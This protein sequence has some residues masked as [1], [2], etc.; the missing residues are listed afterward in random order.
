MKLNP[1]DLEKI[2]DLTLKH[3]NQS[4]EDFREG[5]RDHN[6]SQNIEAL[7]QYIEGDPPFT[8]FD[9]GC[10]PGRDLK[11]FAE[12]GH[13]AVGL[14]GAARFDVMARVQQPWLASVWRRLAS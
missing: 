3:Y 1:Q 4:A 9:F 2:A 5:T 11:V 8:I 7:L 13:I 6:V 10:G 12:L 14:E